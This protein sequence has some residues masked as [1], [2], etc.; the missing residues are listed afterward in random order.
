MA[1]APIHLATAYA[2]NATP[3]N[4]AA[5]NI[6]DTK[7]GWTA[8]AGGAYALSHNLAIKVEWLYSDFGTVTGTATTPT[9]FATITSSAKIK[10]NLVRM[11]VDYKF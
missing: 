4:A 3:P 6:D 1:M 2:D 8:G 5:I 7:T 10:S 11:G 9:G